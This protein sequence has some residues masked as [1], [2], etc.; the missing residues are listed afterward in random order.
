MYSYYFIINTALDELYFLSYNYDHVIN[1][2]FIKRMSI[3]PVSPIPACNKI[4]QDYWNFI[5]DWLVDCLGV[6]YGFANEAEM[7]MSFK[8]MFWLK[9]SLMYINGHIFVV[10]YSLVKGQ[11]GHLTLIQITTQPSSIWPLSLK[12]SLK[13][14]VAVKEIIQYQ[15]PRLYI[16]NAILYFLSAMIMW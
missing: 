9:H 6:L 5:S 12:L 13:R 15:Y 10:L 8:C 3:A 4:L 11:S 1:E 2:C 16:M 14:L 7:E